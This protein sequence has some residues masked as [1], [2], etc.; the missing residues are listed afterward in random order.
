MIEDATLQPVPPVVEEDSWH[1]K[2]QWRRI[3]MI[4]QPEL[5]LRILKFYPNRGNKT[6]LARVLI[7]RHIEELEKA[8]ADHDR[9][10][11]EQLLIVK[12]D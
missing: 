12:V 3:S 6:Y 8:V 2:A 5:M 1:K 10:T 4:V 11:L 9:A 7:R